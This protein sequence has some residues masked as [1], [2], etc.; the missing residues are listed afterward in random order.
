M[1]IS[2]DFDRIL[3]FLNF[4]ENN[5]LHSMIFSTEN[6]YSKLFLDRASLLVNQFFKFLQ[7]IL[8]Q[9]KR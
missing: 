6:P 2:S 5:Y 1:M 7:L 8:G 9:T 3:R 4:A